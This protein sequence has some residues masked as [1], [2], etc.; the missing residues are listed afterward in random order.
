MIN[1]TIV[2]LKPKQGFLDWMASLPDMEPALIPSLN[3]ARNDECFTFLVPEY[4]TVEQAQEYVL[5]QSKFIIK[6]VCDSWDRRE[7]LWPK[8]KNRT[9]LKQW[10]DLE[11]HSEIFDLAPGTIEV[12]EF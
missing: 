8:N 6:F 9:L 4:D 5:K 7:D 11:I 3:D 12:E 2:V 10:F 1:R